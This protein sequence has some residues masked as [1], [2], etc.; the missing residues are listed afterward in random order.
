MRARLMNGLP[1]L[2]AFLIICFLAAATVRGA[3]H[4]GSVTFNGVPVPGAMVT[5]VRGDQRTSV[6]SARDGSYRFPDLADGPW[7]IQVEMRG[8]EPASRE[9]VVAAG[10]PVE[11]WTLSLE[12]FEAMA[13]AA[14]PQAPVQTG[15]PSGTAPPSGAPRTPPRSPS[16][17]AA[18]GAPAASDQP[19]PAPAGDDPLATAARNFNAA[20]G[21]LI[22]GSVNNGAASP[23]A[24]MAAFGNNRR[25]Q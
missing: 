24:Q 17:P 16:T 14:T 15:L 21:L 2:S 10:Q 18:P 1:R 6:H 5:A 19:R 12:S 7:T 25:G 11:Q 3:E 22:N 8:F 23:F 13:R 4:T 9:I 20:D